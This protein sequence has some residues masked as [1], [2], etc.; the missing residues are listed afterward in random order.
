MV[1]ECAFIDG[2]EKLAGI[3]TGV[4]EG[5]ERYAETLETSDEELAE[6]NAGK[7]AEEIELEDAVAARIAAPIVN[8]LD[9]ITAIIN[10]ATEKVMAMIA[11]PS[12]DNGQT[13]GGI[14]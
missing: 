14:K 7:T 4:A 1:N 2:I 9:G 5:L 8:A 13:E 11:E 6:L 10:G 3:L 12:D